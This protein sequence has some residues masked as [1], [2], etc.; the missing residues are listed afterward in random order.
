MKHVFIFLFLFVLVFSSRA[1]HNRAGEILYQRIPPFTSVVGSSTV[2]V[3]TYS[4]SVIRYTDDGP[5]I[6]DRCVD[7]VYFGDGSSGIAP[8]INGSAGICGCGFFNGTMAI[9]CGSLIVNTTNYRVK[10]SVYSITHTY[11]GPGS[12]LIHSFDPNRNQGVHNIPNSVNT[13][14]YI[15]SLMIINASLG[16]NSSPVLTNPPIDQ[17]TVGLCFYHNPG[18]VDADGDSLSYEITTC[19]GVNGLTVPGY[20]DPET[21]S[22][23]SFTINPV[24]GLLS[25]CNPQF[26]DEYNIAIIVKEWRKN[27]GGLY[28]MIGYVLRDMQVLVEYRFVGIKEN[29]LLNN[30]KVYPNPFHEKLEIDLGDQTVN[31]VESWIYTN[32]GKLI[33]KAQNENVGGKL[34]FSVNS[35]EPGIYLLRIKTD[36]GVLYKKIV[37]E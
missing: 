16:A 31:K 9:G 30:L 4:I 1:T 28:Q 22:S 10:Y 12:Y 35:M 25:W 18:A 15:E 13:P 27:S 23:G 7:T 19:R 36:S 2:Q 5:G 26:I 24:T 14:F 34:S 8:R 17:G 32:D 3:Y 33:F 20:F 6:A 21:G 11:S 37:K 29:Q